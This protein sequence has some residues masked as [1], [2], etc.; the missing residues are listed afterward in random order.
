MRQWL[1]TIE[2]AGILIQ[3]LLQYAILDILF[4][5]PY[6]PNTVTSRTLLSVDSPLQ[7][8]CLPAKVSGIPILRLVELR[9]RDSTL[10]PKLCKSAHQAGLR[11]LSP[12]IAA[13]LAALPQAV[14]TYQLSLLGRTLRG[15][16]WQSPALRVHLHY[17]TF[18]CLHD[19]VGLS[20]SPVL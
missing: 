8:Y 6:S 17:Y 13:L 4:T 3:G 15:S 20:Y 2:S 19:P 11:C 5:A 14:L 16:W 9:P 12:L 7:L 10:D 1:N 18:S